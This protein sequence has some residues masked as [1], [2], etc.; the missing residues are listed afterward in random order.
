MRKIDEW[1]AETIKKGFMENGAGVYSCNNTVVSAGESTAEVILF[2]N[3]IA[4][5]NGNRD[6]ILFTLAGWNTQTTRARL[7]AILQTWGG[8]ARI[9]SIKKVPCFIAFN[10]RPRVLDKN[11]DYQ[12]VFDGVC[13]TLREYVTKEVITKY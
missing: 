1:T 4:I 2:G 3:R 7:N 8:G 12:L 5:I 13:F 11:K 10:S 6:K 9:S